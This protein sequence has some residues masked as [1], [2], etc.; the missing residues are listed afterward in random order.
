MR[1]AQ[2]HYHNPAALRWST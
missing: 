2:W 1:I